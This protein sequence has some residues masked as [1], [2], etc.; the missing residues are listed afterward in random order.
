VLAIRPLEQHSFGKS[1]IIEG[2]TEKV[3]KFILP[4][5][6]IYKNKKCFNNLK[7]IIECS[8]KAKTIKNL[9]NYV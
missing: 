1:L 7:C 2:A 4:L 5:K 8:G 9:Y 6:S 3:S